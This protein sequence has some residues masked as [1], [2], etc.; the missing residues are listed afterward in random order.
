MKRDDELRELLNI[1]DKRDR[2]R[3]NCESSSP[4]WKTI[5]TTRTHFNIIV[6]IS[7]AVKEFKQHFLEIWPRVKRA[8][9]RKLVIAGTVS[10]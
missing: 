8:R 4:L 2:S 10:N 6:S 7:F 9:I 3:K 5:E 1:S